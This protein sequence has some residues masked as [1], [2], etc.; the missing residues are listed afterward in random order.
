MTRQ[1]SNPKE[2]ELKI[3]PIQPLLGGVMS[4]LFF[5]IFA[6]K[7]AFNVARDHATSL[8]VAQGFSHQIFL[9]GSLKRWASHSKES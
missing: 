8:R 1:E 3:E 9:L 6:F 5:S 7:A 4:V 2:G